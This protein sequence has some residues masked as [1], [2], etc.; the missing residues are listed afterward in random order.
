MNNNNDND[1]EKK[2]F[3][4][5]K[6][7]AE[8]NMDDAGIAGWSR[9]GLEARLRYFIHY[10]KPDTLNNNMLWADIGCGAGTYSNL[11]TKY[12]NTVISVDYS[13]TSLVKAKE[14]YGDSILWTVGNAKSL[15]FKD[16][17][18]DGALCF[19]V[20]QALDDVRPMLTD[21]KRILSPGG[22]IWIDALNKWCLPN[23][24]EQ[25]YRRTKG[26]PQHLRYDSPRTFKL[27]MKE[28]GYTDIKIYCLPLLPKRLLW[29]QK[30]IEFPITNK[31][32][33]VLQPITF[34]ISHSFIIKATA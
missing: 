16:N 26:I 11:L 19:G 23:L 8:Q 30:F 22:V 4:I 3:K 21:I 17:L 31:I 1:F 6:T 12:N 34:L 7:F 28:S 33:N 29:L 2:W 18:V 32:I 24:W 20:S 9:T 5:F 10:C 25:L 15:P 13:H 14:K 27:L